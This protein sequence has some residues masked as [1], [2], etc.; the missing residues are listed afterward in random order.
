MVTFTA[1]PSGSLL[2]QE[3]FNY[4]P[5]VSTSVAGGGGWGN[6]FPDITQGAAGFIGNWDWNAAGAKF[7]ISAADA[8]HTDGAY[9]D[10]STSTNGQRAPFSIALPSNTPVY[11]SMLFGKTGSNNGHFVFWDHGGYNIVTLAINSSGHYAL[12]V[13]QGTT[14]DTTIPVNAT[15]FDQILMAITRADQEVW[16][17]ATVSL[18]V[19]PNWSSLGAPAV[20]GTASTAYP[21]ISQWLLDGGGMAVDRIRIGTTLADVQINPEPNG[22]AFDTWAGTGTGGKGLTGTA[23]AF[24]ADPDYDGITNGI[25]FVIGGEPNPANPGSNSSALLPTAAASGTNL[26][27]THTRTHAAAYLNPFVEFDADMQGAWTTATSGNATIAVVTGSTADTVIVTI[28]KGSN[29]KLF[30]RL[31][32]V[33]TP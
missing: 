22:S 19:N 1:V 23:A 31:K 17:N 7:G 20:T 18:W 14:V 5:G 13:G 25:E 16:G 21:D 2:L 11:Q 6:S 24:D 32:V 4:P 28:P 10:G 27:F 26:V 30:A 33:N 15:G 3:D 12:A 29:S 8:N 9:Y